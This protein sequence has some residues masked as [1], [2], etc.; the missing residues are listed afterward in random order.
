LEKAYYPKA[1]NIID[2]VHE[3]MDQK[4]LGKRSFRSHGN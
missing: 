3:V 4:H 2:A 1:Q